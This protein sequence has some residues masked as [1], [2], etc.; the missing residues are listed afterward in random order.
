MVNITRPGALFSVSMGACASETLCAE[1][2][3][4]QVI[5]TASS[6][7]YARAF[8]PVNFKETTFAGSLVEKL[9]KKVISAPCWYGNGYGA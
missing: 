9:D 6:A 1:T 7:L 2:P 8:K 4:L 5:P 3:K